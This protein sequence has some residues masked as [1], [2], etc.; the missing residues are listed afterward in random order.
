MA[1]PIL[2]ASAAIYLF[3]VFAGLLVM[4]IVLFPRVING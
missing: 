2:Q 3:Y 4:E 1:Q